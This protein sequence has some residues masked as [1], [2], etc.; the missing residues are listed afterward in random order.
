[1]NVSEVIVD[2]LKQ[3]NIHHI[4]G[5]PGDPSVEFLEACRKKNMSFVLARREGTAGLMAEAYGML[6]GKPGVALSTL[7]PGSTN[8][9]NAVANAYLD[10]TPMIAIS[11][12]I[13]TKRLP[14][15]THQVVDQHAIFAPVA[16]Y[17]ADVMPHTAAHV[18]RKS[19]KIACSPRPGP[20]HLSTPADTIGAQASDDQILLPPV[21]CIHSSMQLMNQTNKTLEKTI[22]EAKKPIILLGISAM[23]NNAGNSILALAEKIGAAIVTSPM[24]KGTV[25]E[26]HPLFAGTLDMACNET[27]WSFMNSADLVIAAGFDAVELIK[28]WS[29]KAPVI[30]IDTVDNSDQIYAAGIECVGSITDILDQ[31]SDSVLEAEKYSFSDVSKQRDELQTAFEAGRVKAK[32]RMDPSD[33]VR[34]VSE[35]SPEAIV[36]TDVG[37]HKLLVGQGWHPTTPRK[38]L[39][40]NGLSSMGFSLPAAITAQMMNPE[41][42]VICFT[43]D[44]GL[45]MVQSELRLASSLNVSLKVIVF[46]DNSLN[47]IELKQMDKNYASTGTIIESTDIPKMAESMSCHGI[48]VTNESELIKALSIDHA[49][50]PLVI[51]VKVDPSQYQA[52]F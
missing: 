33:V 25:S 18:M 21:N 43:G 37:S 38:I 28:P 11:G 35:Y 20:V 46:V 48:N 29:V 27:M 47:R 6:T 10:R 45:A 15:F 40:T 39:M 12:Q 22:N 32:N 8:L 51:G 50:V 17:V 36:T 1:M 44:G 52:Q 19:H 5:Y 49:N 9:V 16:K 23:Q 24:A 42:Q 34:V 3:A 4:F 2:Y 31:L 30:H 26:N 14:T 7:G 41:K 13:D